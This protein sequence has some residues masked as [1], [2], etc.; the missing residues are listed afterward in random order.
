MMPRKSI[1]LDTLPVGDLAYAIRCL[2]ANRKTTEAEVLHFVRE[3][4][5][6][7]AVIQVELKALLAGVVLAAPA[8]ATARK[9][10]TAKAAPTKQSS[11]RRL[12]G[13]YMGLI[14]NFTGAVRSRI[15]GLAKA[16]GLPAGIAEM[17]K[18]LTSKTKATTPRK[19]GAKP[20]ATAARKLGTKPRVAKPKRVA[21][22]VAPRKLKLSPARRAALKI[23]G[24]YIGL[25]RSLPAAEK[26]KMKVLAAKS[27]MAAA[28]VTMRRGKR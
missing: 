28:V 8:A 25:L 5:Q 18:L 4:V 21:A 17:T 9:P 10:P 23:Q 3:R 26:A 27:G 20:K 2:I 13:R 11:F 22:K 1:T 15:K 6:R 19:L 12:Q 7:I 16:K 24:T 14:R